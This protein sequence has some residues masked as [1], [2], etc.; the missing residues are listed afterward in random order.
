MKF[1]LRAAFKKLGVTD[2]AEAV[3]AAIRRG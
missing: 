1:H 2:R 3:M